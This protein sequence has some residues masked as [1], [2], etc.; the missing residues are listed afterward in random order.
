MK[1]TLRPLLLLTLSLL[2]AGQLL[3][4]KTKVAC[5]GDSITKR[6]FPAELATMLDV[7]TINAGVAGNTSAQGLHRMNRDV[8]AKSPDIVVV[9]FGTNDIRVDAKKHVKL[10]DYRKNLQE[11]INRCQKQGAKVVLC[12]PPPIDTA[13][14]FKRHDQKIYDDAGGLSHLLTQYSLAAGEVASKNKVPVV[15]LHQL[16]LGDKQWMHKDG[17]HPSPAGNTIIAK[18]VA[19][20]VRPLLPAAS[21]T[22]K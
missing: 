9:F 11:I 21:S 18:H 22:K 2:S 13:A 16:L 10:D 8:L 14:Y 6:G 4:E 5:L 7:E 3:A 17:V 1:S 15:E 12:T 19:T 20:A